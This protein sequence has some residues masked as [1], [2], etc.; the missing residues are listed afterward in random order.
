MTTMFKPMLAVNSKPEDLKK[1]QLGSI[2]LEGVRGIF[3]PE[4]GLIGRSL[5]PLANSLL[6]DREDFQQIEKYC[7]AN[8]IYLEGELYVHG[9]T[10]NRIDS[11]IRGE[12]N[13]DARKLEFHVFDCFVPGVPDATFTQRVAFYKFA[14]GELKNLGVNC[15]FACEQTLMQSADDIRQ[16]YIWAI[17]NGY[18][19]FCLKAA[20]LP[21]KHGRSTLKQEYFTRIKPEK[22]YDAVILNIIER[23]ENLC[24]SEVNELGYLKKRQD[25]DMK[26][27]TGIAQ[28]ALV[29]TPQ[30]GKVHKISLTRGL[31]DPD[32]MRIWEDA[33]FYEGKA[34]QFVGIPVPGQA[35][36]R[37]PRFD[38]WR[39]D[40][41]VT[42]M[43]H[44]A[45]DAVFVEWDQAKI[46]DL[47]EGGCEII[48]WEVFNDRLENGWGID[49]TT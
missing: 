47:L 4:D 3:A 13:V 10:F 18:E 22:T 25:K 23:Q 14:V 21:Y 33:G 43:Q 32:R 15:V 19:G 2:K 31:T 29:F 16:A 42:F 36:P 27:G 41:E 26:R 5:K 40:I 24:E 35:V 9:W 49:I 8:G 39:H 34:V 44:D 17:E 20:E 45:S 38:K 28:S 11:C 6:Y 30:I 7:E 48:S 46:Q 12:G 1:P 37:S